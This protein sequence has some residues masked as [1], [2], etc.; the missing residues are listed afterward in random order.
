MSSSKR[1]IRNIIVGIAVTSAAGLALFGA[2]ST[3]AD[4]TA[5]DTGSVQVGTATLSLNLSDAG[6]ST[7]TFNLA[8]NNLQPGQ[9]MTKVFYIKNTGTIP[10]T[11]RL[12]APFT[13]GQLPSGLTGADYSE[14]L[15]GVDG[16]A[17]LAP[18]PAAA[19]GFNLGVIQPGQTKAVTVRV[20]LASG[21]GNEWQG[22]TLS[23]TATVTL[24]QL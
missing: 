14:L 11:A 3:G 23:A 20:G 13:V 16:V 24:N 22:K 9:E 6:G 19:N 7:G 1:N 21:A 15:V 5:S 2:G 8:Y 18:A 10:A 4:F 17:A 12:G